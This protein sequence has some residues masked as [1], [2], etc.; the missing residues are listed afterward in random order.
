M[1]ITIDE[2]L[3]G[4]PTVIKGKNY[5][6]TAAYVEPFLERLH[7]LTDD[8]RVHVQLPDQITKTIR[9][10]LLIIEYISKLLCQMKYAMIIMIRLSVWL[11][12]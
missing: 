8:F 10:I 2:L 6:G 5:F 3:K 9:M 1:D 12:D 11:W 7:N 4:K